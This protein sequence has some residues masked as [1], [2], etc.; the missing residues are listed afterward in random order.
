MSCELPQPTR[1]GEELQPADVRGDAQVRGA[2]WSRGLGPTAGG[3]EGKEGQ[4]KLDR[5]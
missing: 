1:A 5:D 3:E 4:E 2:P